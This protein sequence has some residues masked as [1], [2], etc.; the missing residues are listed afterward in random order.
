MKARLGGAVKQSQPSGDINKRESQ[1][2]GQLGYIKKFE[3][4]LSQRT[5]KVFVSAILGSGL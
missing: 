2:Q 4:Y 3:N 1:L 5:P